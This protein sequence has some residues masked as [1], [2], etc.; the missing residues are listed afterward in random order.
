MGKSRNIAR[1][2]VD[3][4]GAVDAT[5]LG[6]A[7]PADGSITEAKLASDSVTAA[8]IATGAVGADELAATAVTA[9]TYGTASA[10]PAITVDADGRITGV[11]TNSVS[12]TPTTAQVLAATAGASAGEVGAYSFLSHGSNYGIQTT[13][14][15]RAGSQLRYSGASSG[16]TV[17]AVTGGTPAGTWR[18]MGYIQEGG[19]TSTIYVPS[20]WLR[21]S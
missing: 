14:S 13:G 19:A 21:I 18:L 12:A 5:N 15:T 17:F 8:K 2:V 6:N 10:I 16:D 1:L 20:V 4:T 11:T 7:V 9:G 3:A